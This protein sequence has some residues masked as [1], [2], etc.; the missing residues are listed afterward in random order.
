MCYTRHVHTLVHTYTQ[1]LRQTN[2]LIFVCASAG[3][4]AGV[5]V[6]GT[7]RNS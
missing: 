1:L 5:G 7:E 4:S 6:G 2:G 3:A